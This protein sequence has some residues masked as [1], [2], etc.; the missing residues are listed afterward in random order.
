MQYI[1]QTFYLQSLRNDF[2]NIFYVLDGIKATAG[3]ID[4]FA[5]ILITLNRFMIDL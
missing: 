3:N 2:V 5:K 1:K 4:S